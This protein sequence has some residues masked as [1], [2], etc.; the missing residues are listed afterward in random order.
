MSKQELV[1]HSYYPSNSGSPTLVLIHGNGL[2]RDCWEPLV[3]HLVR[4]FNVLSMDLPGHGDYVGWEGSLPDS[5]ELGTLIQRF[6]MDRGMEH[7]F[8]FGSI[9]L[10]GHGFGGNIALQVASLAPELVQSLVL[11]SSVFHVPASI[12]DKY[13]D[14]LRSIFLDE[15]QGRER[16]TD[17]ML[18]LVTHNERHYPVLKNAYGIVNLHMMSHYYDVLSSTNWTGI[19]H[20]IDCPVL[21]ISGEFDP[22]ISPYL[23]IEGSRLMQNAVLHTAPGALNAVFMD[24]PAETADRIRRFVFRSPPSL[25]KP[26][27]S[28]LHSELRRHH[29]RVR[30]EPNKLQLSLI[31]TFSVKVNN[32][33]ITDG[34]NKRFAKEIL[35]YL[36]LN[37]WTTRERLIETFW[38]DAE[39]GKAR[40]S[41]RVS[42]NYMKTLFKESA[43]IEIIHAGREQIRLDCS[44]H[45]DVADMLSA[46]TE[47][48]KEDNLMKIEANVR[49]YVEVILEEQY[50]T[51]F[52]P[53]WFIEIKNRLSAAMLYQ[54]EKLHRHYAGTDAVRAK[55]YQYYLNRHG[56]GAL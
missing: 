52:Y 48:A 33:E 16:L 36:A 15:Y 51:D 54:V 22:V 30:E 45:C 9:H 53:N 8:D 38:P 42:L 40:N 32:R 31:R 23:T 27:M 43:G 7:G 17:Y 44:V 28:E 6:I 24:A 39:I 56:T 1:P 55:F 19:A 14:F 46:V 3:P 35:V 21:L 49:S 41:L 20:Q 12:I 4:S 13:V 37:E 25:T 5:L 2:N 10:V 29:K 47:L 50:L 34:W 18:P 26:I 11:I